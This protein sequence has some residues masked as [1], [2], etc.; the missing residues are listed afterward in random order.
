MKNNKIKRKRSR[1]KNNI[2]DNRRIVLIFMNFKNIYVNLVFK[3]FSKV[4]K[5]VDQLF[6]NYINI[7]FNNFFVKEFVIFSLYCNEYLCF[8]IYNNIN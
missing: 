2:N 4:I 6:N 7:I 5:D 3:I 1:F 8:L